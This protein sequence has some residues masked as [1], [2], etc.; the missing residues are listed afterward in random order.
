M[1]YEELHQVQI[2]FY[3][4]GYMMGGRVCMIIPHAKEE[5]YT[6]WDDRINIF[7]LEGMIQAH[8]GG[9]RTTLRS[10]TTLTATAPRTMERMAGVVVVPVQNS[11]G[12]STVSSVVT[13]IHKL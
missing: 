6:W 2:Y 7:E 1:I 8:L 13:K 5:E 12:S 10:S 3:G 4:H 9:V 11:L